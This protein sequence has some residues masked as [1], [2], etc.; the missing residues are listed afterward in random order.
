M[1]WKQ[2]LGTKNPNL[3][4]VFQN[5]QENEKNSRMNILRHAQGE[6]PAPQKKHYREYNERI[7]R[8]KN[9]YLS[10]SLT[11]RQYCITVHR[12]ASLLFSWNPGHEN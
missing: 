8:I 6:T 3:W 4:K 1:L 12:Q 9:S 10:G 7:T 2:K 5:I 11:V